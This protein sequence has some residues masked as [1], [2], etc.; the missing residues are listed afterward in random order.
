[1]CCALEHQTLPVVS[2][3]EWSEDI[4]WCDAHLLTNH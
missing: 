4:R 2:T 3:R 1:M